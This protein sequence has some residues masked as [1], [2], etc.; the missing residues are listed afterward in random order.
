[1]LLLLLLAEA[2]LAVWTIDQRRNG[3]DR[4]FARVPEFKSSRENGGDAIPANFN[5]THRVSITKV[6]K[7]RL[8]GRSMLMSCCAGTGNGSIESD[9]KLSPKTEIGLGIENPRVAV[10]RELREAQQGV[11]ARRMKL[12]M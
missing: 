3:R 2:R 5:R 4:E 11:L 7:A 9:G 10:L 1:L 6:D 12:K 8:D